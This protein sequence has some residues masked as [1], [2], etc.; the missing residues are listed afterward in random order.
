MK[1]FERLSPQKRQEEIQAAAL[2]I[3]NE[4]GFAATTM[5]NIVQQVSLSKGGV[6]RIYPSTTAILSDLMLSG[7]HL[8]NAYYEERVKKEI[9]SGRELTLEFIIGMIADSMLISPEISSVYVEFLWQKQRNPQL[10]ELYQRICAM[11]VEETKTL[12]RNYNA[13]SLLLADESILVQMTELMN[14]AILS[15][16]VLHLQDYFLKN[17]EKICKAILQILKI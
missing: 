5:E 4:K 15:I 7:M 2:K 16:H 8:R 10:E 9:E 13:D 17:K 6:Y 3:F 12:I 1:K 11:S 14:A